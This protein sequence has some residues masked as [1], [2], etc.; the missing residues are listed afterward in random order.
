MNDLKPCPFC[1]GINIIHSGFRMY[2]HTCGAEGPDADNMDESAATEAWNTRA[3]LAQPADME[4]VASIYITP[5]GK[6]EFDDWRHDLPV[7]VNLL[8]THPPA[9]VPLTEQEIWDA[10]QHGVVGGIGMPSKAIAVAR[11]IEAAHGIGETK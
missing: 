5:S 8:Y 2:C 6:R 10:V 4:P 1:G 3:A 7:G 9:R 11:A